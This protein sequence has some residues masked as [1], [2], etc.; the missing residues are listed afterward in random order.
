MRVFQ[1]II[2]MKIN[3]YSFEFKQITLILKKNTIQIKNIKYEIN[4]QYTIWKENCTM[5]RETNQMDKKYTCHFSLHFWGR[6][7]NV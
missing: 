3:Q 7:L 1:L 5:Q 6:G 2:Q 4:T